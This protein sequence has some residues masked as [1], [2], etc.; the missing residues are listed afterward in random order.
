M[1]GD[2]VLANPADIDLLQPTVR[3]YCWHPAAV[4]LGVYQLPATVDCERC[5]QMNWDVSRRPTGGR[6][7]LHEGDLSYSVV[8]PGGNKSPQDLRV[9]YEAVAHAWAETLGKFGL[10]AELISGGHS[11]R[12]A[13]PHI[14]DGLCLDSRVRGELAVNNKKITAAAQ[15]IYRNSILQHGSVTLKGDVGAISAVLPLDEDARQISRQKLQLS[16]TT[17]AHETGREISARE[18]LDAAIAPFSRN[19]NFSLVPAGWRDD[20]LSEIE[21]RRKNHFVF[22]KF[23]DTKSC[24]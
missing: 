18:L 8:L 24:E 5:A 22:S 20:E 3:F 7:L 10:K 19:L 14:R 1:S 16:A 11:T 23:I 21:S 6:A 17:L 9:L 2:D 13:T 4:S 12:D 15:R